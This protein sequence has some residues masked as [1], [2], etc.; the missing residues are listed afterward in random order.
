MHR[1]L[2]IA[3]S[4]EAK[5]HRCSGF[6]HTMVQKQRDH[7][8]FERYTSATGRYWG[9]L[10][11]MAD[12]EK[13]IFISYPHLDSR[14]VDQLSADLSA[15]GVQVW[16]DHSG[17]A[18]GTPNWEKAIRDAL[19]ASSAMLLVASRSSRISLAVQ[20]EVSVA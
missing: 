15:A 14:F 18:P 11:T 10:R 13:R 4:L 9:R 3:K 6:D 7:S 2:R 19:R 8:Y 17:L 16:I 20:G 1:A 5:P 12:T